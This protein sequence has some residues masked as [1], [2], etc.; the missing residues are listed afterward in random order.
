MSNRLH[1]SNSA[2]F[3]IMW[4]TLSGLVW[5][6]IS[7]RHRQGGNGG[8]YS[9]RVVTR[10]FTLVDD[11][12]TTRA[13]IGMSDKTNAPCV[14]L[15]D[16]KGAQRAQL[17]LNKDDVPSLRLYSSDGKI[18]S[19][20]GFVN[21]D[22]Q[23]VFVTFDPGGT[24]HIEN[25][26]GLNTAHSLFDEDLSGGRYVQTYR[27]DSNLIFGHYSGTVTADDCLFVTTQQAQVNAEVA[28]AQAEQAALA[29]QQARL[30]AELEAA[31][32]RLQ[33]K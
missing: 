33:A 29:A 28:R 7:L 31:R 10:E 30:Q 23:P 25:Q 6:D 1:L 11:S 13:R 16:A 26:T 22:M 24:G 3:A 14:Q 18:K 8:S 19:V 5:H 17:R 32:A 20:V 12:G 15:F 21:N 27:G 4:V 9:D 2:V